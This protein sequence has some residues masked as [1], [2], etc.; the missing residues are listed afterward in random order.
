M[1]RSAKMYRF[2]S[3]SLFLLITF[4]LAGCSGQSA[5]TPVELSS[6]AL[7]EDEVPELPAFTYENPGENEWELK[8]LSLSEQGF[9][10]L[11]NRGNISREE[12][13]F[14]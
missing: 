4:S 12:G 8:R 14:F 7:L 11:D 2:I 13:L 3:L 6:S 9:S 10:V 5:P 1:S